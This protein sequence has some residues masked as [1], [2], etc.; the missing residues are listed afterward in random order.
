MSVVALL[1]AVTACSTS[2]PESKATAGGG[3]VP[4]ETQRMADTLAAIYARAIAK[5]DANPF[6]NRER[7][8]DVELELKG[9]SGPQ[10]MEPRFRLAEERLKAGRTQEAIDGLESLITD[11]GISWDSIAPHQKPFFDLIAIAYMRLGEQQ[12]CLDN[13]A[14][15]ICI[16]P[17][18]GGARHTKKAGARGAIER[19]TKILRQYPDDRGSQ[20]LL[21]L[22]YLQ[23]GEYP[24]GVPAQY[25]IRN[26]APA[27]GASGFPQYRNVSFDVGL[28]V[29]GLAGGTDVDDFNGDGL[30]DVFTTAWGLNDPVHLFIADGKGGYADRSASSGLTGIVGGLNTTHADY[31]NDGDVDILVMRGAWM[32]ESGPFPL[33]LLR[34]TGDGR[35]EDVTIGAGLLSY[36]P[37]NTAA[38][39]DFDLDGYLD[40]FVGYESYSKLNGGPSHRSKLFL[41]NRNGTFTD[42]SAKVGIDV[43][44]FVKASTWGDINNDGL[45]DLYLSVIY[46]RNKLFINRGGSSIDTWRFEEVAAAAGVQK[47]I[48]SF[49][50]WFWDFDNDGRDDIFVPSYDVNAAMHEMV[51]R[52]A[53]GLPLSVRVS[54]VDVTYEDPRLYR[55][56]G[57]GT[58]EDV[59]AKAGLSG[60]VIFA[61][62]SNFGDL[63]NDGFLDF[64]IGTGNPDLRS[65]IPNRMF[66]N[67]GGTRFEEVTLPGGFGHLQKG[68][69]VAFADLDRDG[70]EDVFEVIGGAYQGDLATSVLFENPGWPKTSWINLQLEG[71]T[72]NRSAIGARVEVVAVDPSGT[73]RSIHRTIGTGG[74]FGAGPLQLHVGLGAAARITE[75]RVQW[76]DSARSRTSYP[77][78]AA[79]RFWHVTQG[80]APV[81]LERPPVPFRA[82]PIG[83]PASMTMPMPK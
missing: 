42:V 73:T 19:Y 77:A 38:W 31:D 56:R 79:N 67:D 35:F 8:A 23:L 32:R 29:T 40:L 1:L 83:L 3:A 4:G 60:K 58:F 28:A 37:T 34:N 39:R 21:N 76:P 53:L 33:S 12:N 30:L 5:P 70:D 11:A 59:T 22:A 15:N 78:L 52:E 20:W 54:G 69:A 27:S 47:P 36:G 72:A 18:E 46:G 41:N 6:L 45:P 74:S 14:A 62:G 65:V 17:L 55:N 75:V 43:D 44:D 9:L 51:A 26:L 48:A 7:A 61:M 64:Y 13:P 25:L 66:R 50:A 24:A 10:T 80:K 49:P 68:H 16:L 82:T 2:A 57:D 63:D 71:T 81:A